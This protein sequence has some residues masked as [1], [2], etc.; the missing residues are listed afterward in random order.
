M[1]GAADEVLDAKVEAA[2]ENI[3]RRK[4]ADA[5]LIKNANQFGGL[6]AAGA[7]LFDTDVAAMF[8]ESVSLPSDTDGVNHHDV[9]KKVLLEK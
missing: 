6:D 9:A 4:T 3:R 2:T 8:D 5:S 7:A 1:G